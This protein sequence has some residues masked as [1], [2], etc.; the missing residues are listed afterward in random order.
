M[1]N[2]RLDVVSEG[3][4]AF[5]D[6]IDIALEQ[7]RAASHFVV[8]DYPCVVNELIKADG[9]R[10]TLILFWSEDDSFEPK[11]SAFP[12][13]M[14]GAPLETFVWNWLEDMWE[15]KEHGPQPN[16]DGHNENGW[17]IFNE[18]W[19]HLAGSQYGIIAIQPIWATY[20]K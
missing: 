3:K 7:H 19:G 20:G 13:D 14:K 17:R 9:K 11:P 16:H 1:D 8:I 12:S 15:K 5:S 18:Y 2:F 6:A 4:D 10:K